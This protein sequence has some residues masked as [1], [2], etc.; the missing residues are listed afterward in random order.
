[1]SP[2]QVFPRLAFKEELPPAGQEFK[3]RLKAALTRV[4]FRAKEL[5]VKSVGH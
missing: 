4:T 5:H 2:G 3:R 1:M